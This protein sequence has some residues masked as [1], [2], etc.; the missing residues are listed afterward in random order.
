MSFL[1]ISVLGSFAQDTVIRKICGVEF[2]TD[3]ETARRVLVSTY[4]TPSDDM[5][6]YLGFEDIDY[7]GIRFSF[8]FFTFQHDAS[9]SY[10]NDVMLIIKCKTA[11]EAKNKRERLR[12]IL[13][14]K[15]ELSEGTNDQKFKYY[16]GGV[17][18]TNPNDYGFILGVHKDKVT[19]GGGYLVTLKYGRYNYVDESF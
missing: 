10:L 2:G 15:Y 19:K 13:E 9:T 5:F 7:A 14:Q 17:S 3:Q 12:R 11:D 8:A 18:P 16:Q 1:A 6:K 4:G